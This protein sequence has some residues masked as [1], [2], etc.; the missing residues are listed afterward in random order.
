VPQPD[1]ADVEEVLGEARALIEAVLGLHE[2]VGVALRKAFARGLLDVPFCLHEDNRGLTQSTIDE[3]GRLRWARIGHL[4]LPRRVTGARRR[5]TSTELLTMLRHTA[6]EHDKVALPAPAGAQPAELTGAEPRPYRIAVIGTGPRGLAVV[7]RLAARLAEAPTAV[8]VELYAMDAVQVGPGRIWRTSQ[9]R[10]LLMNTPAGEVTMFSG[11]PDD[12]PTRAGAGPSLAQWWQA[13]DPAG[14]PHAY[15]P[16]ALY[17]QYMRYVLNRVDGG[18]PGWAR[19]HRFYAQV[20]DVHE[21]PDGRYRLTL[22]DG[23]QLVVDR[24]VL[25]TGH[26][27]PTLDPP[28]RALAEFAATRPHLRYLRGDSAADLPLAR[29]PARARVGVLGLGLS[30]YDVLIALTVGRGGTFTED[31]GG[32][33]HYRAS[34]REPHVLAGSRSGIPIL[35]RGRNQKPGEHAYRPRLFTHERMLA[36]RARGP[37]DFGTDVLPW[38]LAEVDLVYLAAVIRRRF[39]ADVADR[40][41]AEAEAATAGPGDR[42]ADPRA[43]LHRIAGRLGVGDLPPVDLY[44]WSRRFAGRD[45]SGPDEFH[46]ELAALLRHDLDLAEEG[47]VD[48]PFKACLDA[49]RDVRG[50]IRTAVDY[51]GLTPAS[52]R[53]E[54]LGWFVPVSASLTTGPPRER[55]RQLLALVEAGVLGVVGPELRWG[56]DPETDAFYVESP[57]VAGSRSTVD[58]LIDARIPGPDLRRETGLLALLRDRGLLTNHVNA[59]PDGDFVT[60]GVSVTRSPFHPVRADGRPEQG[61]YVLGIPTE[62]TRWFTQVGSG[63]PGTWGDFIADAD[64]IAGDAL[65]GAPL[66]EIAELAEPVTVAEPVG[67]GG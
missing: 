55:Q 7:E 12:G 18:L 16:R 59:G 49:I 47:N 38:L 10:W 67:S 29:I 62:H 39:G 13:F 23:R 51:R 36:A 5:V 58:V 24:V 50:V 34:G 6:E 31:A 56:A 45:F 41:V 17:G 61:M 57:R 30:F 1:G 37:L 19:L 15:A 28:Q 33:L 26:A 9:P 2:D 21:N 22:H 46:R 44:A 32:A 60:G 20:A 3:D 63:R 8:P 42:D 27:R 48:G 64:A 14:H 66:D 43:V 11:P 25:T 54:F 52:H 4:P 53:D 65:R 35:A 40:F